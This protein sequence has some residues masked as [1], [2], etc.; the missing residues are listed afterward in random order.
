MK[1]NST[2]PVS[3]WWSSIG[4]FCSRPKRKSTSPI[5]PA[6]RLFPIL[7]GFFEEPGQSRQGHGPKRLSQVRQ[8]NS[9]NEAGERWL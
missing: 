7:A 5:S 2:P 3:L 9:E 8:T 1:A 4:K 6:G